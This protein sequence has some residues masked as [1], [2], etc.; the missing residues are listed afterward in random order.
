MPNT[1][2]VPAIGSIPKKGLLFGGIA[3]LGVVGYIIYRRSQGQ[4]AAGTDTIGTNVTDSGSMDGTYT[5]DPYNDPY[6][7]Y[8]DYGTAGYQ[9]PYA[10]PTTTPATVLPAAPVTNYDWMLQA[11]RS[12]FKTVS[13]TLALRLYLG[14]LP[15]SHDQANTVQEAIGIVGDPP[16]AGPNGYPP[17]FHVAPA[18]GQRHREPGYHFT[19]NGRQTVYQIAHTHGVT[20]GA[21]VSRNTHALHKYVGSGR[22]VPAGIRLWIPA[23]AIRS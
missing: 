19:T 23:H 2:H 4:S 20:E 1:V 22:N 6:S 18:T 7:G 17:K 14:G 9:N 5:G 12:G 15:L 3:G 10:Y 21:L 11:K 8:S 16:V 13:E